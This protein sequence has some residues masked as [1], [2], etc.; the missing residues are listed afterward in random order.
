M[1]NL[2]LPEFAQKGEDIYNTRIK[3]ELPPGLKGKIVA[4][5]VESG[6]YFIEDTPLKAGILGQHKHPNKQFYFKRIGYDTVY[7]SVGIVKK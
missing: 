2:V 6:D 4:I 7:K 3:N 1:S 5:E